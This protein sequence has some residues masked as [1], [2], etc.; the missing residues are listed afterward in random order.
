[1][2]REEAGCHASDK[3]LTVSS[4]H[5]NEERIAGILELKRDQPWG[6]WD[7][8]EI[9]SSSRRDF[10]GEEAPKNGARFALTTCPVLPLNTALAASI[11]WKPIDSAA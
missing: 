5:S 11:P 4:S 6:D 8:G 9:R 2:S 1:M 10:S 7:Q 3:T